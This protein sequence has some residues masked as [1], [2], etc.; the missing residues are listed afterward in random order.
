MLAGIAAEA[1]RESGEADGGKGPVVG[2]QFNERTQLL[3]FKSVPGRFGLAV[4]SDQGVIASAGAGGDGDDR[5]MK[6]DQDFQPLG[7]WLT[8][9]LQDGVSEGGESFLAAAA[10]SFQAG[11]EVVEA[12]DRVAEEPGAQWEV[13]SSELLELDFVGVKPAL[14]KIMAKEQD[15]FAGLENGLEELGGRALNRAGRMLFE[16]GGRDFDRDPVSCT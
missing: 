10:V 5:E 12:V 2:S 4:G 6:S 13:N 16:P 9:G 7:S 1:V 15:F 11:I 3:G 14:V 8:I